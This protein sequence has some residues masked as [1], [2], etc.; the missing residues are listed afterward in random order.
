[1]IKQAFFLIFLTLISIGPVSAQKTASAVRS[2]GLG[3]CDSIVEISK[4]YYDSHQ[5]KLAI[6][7]TADIPPKIGGYSAV[8]FGHDSI[9]FNDEDSDGIYVSSIVGI[10]GGHRWV[11]VKTSDEIKDYF[12]LIDQ[13][14]L[15][16]DTLIGYPYLYRDKMLCVEGVHTDMPGYV[17]LWQINKGK[18]KLIFKDYFSRCDKGLPQ[19]FALSFK[20]E[21]M[22][23]G[24]GKYWLVKGALF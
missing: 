16:I 12:Y 2:Y 18:T 13:A 10:D 15:W 8:K 11:L 3:F 4:E 22:F 9:V 7:D 6:I 21:F 14:R 23:Y 19:S 17:E 5:R 1:M 24:W 20:N